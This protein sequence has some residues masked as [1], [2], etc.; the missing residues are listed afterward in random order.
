MPSTRPPDALIFIGTGCPH[1]PAVLEGLT[2]LLKD[3]RLA[4]LEAVNLAADPDAAARHG[5]RSVPWTRIGP[6][7]LIGALA[8]A[9]LAEWADYAAAGEG[10]SAYFAHLI[11][12]RRL[13]EVVALVRKCA[14]NLSD[15]LHLLV[16]EVTP[17]DTRIG[18]SAVIEE[19]AGSETLT[20][21]REQLEQLTLSEL[22]SARADACHF[23]ALSGDPR[24]A[25]AVRRLLDDEDEAVREIAAETL[26]VLGAGEEG[27]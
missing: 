8:P 23:L 19:L 18:V 25:P 4:R 21:A 26:A 9:E 20:A 3:G 17:L 11:E 27:A 1:C 13:G 12:S 24:A 10:W 15:L 5:V 6:F 2:R 16:S 7:E 14:A 22:A